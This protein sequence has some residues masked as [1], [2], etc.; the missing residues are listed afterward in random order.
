[1]D[2]FVWLTSDGRAYVAN[3]DLLASGSS[4][5]TGRCFH[6]ATKPRKR[7]S[8]T[9][10]RAADAVES[11]EVPH[12]DAEKPEAN[13]DGTQEGAAPDSI[14]TKDNATNAEENVAAAIAEED[15]QAAAPTQD[16]KASG[17]ALNALPTDQH[18]TSVSINAK[19]SLIALGLAD[20]TV[21]VYNYRAPGRTP[22][23]SHTL[24]VRKHSNP[25]QAISP[26]RSLLLVLDK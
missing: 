11:P 13:G 19:F 26:P 2:V 18:A 25:R 17:P 14:S 15:T 10:D 16:T 1:M 3:L 24:S 22:L 9:V 12:A 5:W 8:S 7:P 6:G 23:P 4:P 20:G 21:A